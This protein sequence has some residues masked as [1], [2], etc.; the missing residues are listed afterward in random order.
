MS[1]IDRRIGLL[2]A[3]FVLLLVAVAARAA[4]VQGVHGG[5][6]SADAAGQ[7]SELLDVPAVRGRIMDRNHRELAVSEDAATIYATPYQV[8]DPANAARRLGAVL[9]RDPDDILK[10]LSVRDSGFEYVAQKVNLGVAEAVRKLD[11]EGIGVLPDSR[12][13][14]P[15]G[16][17]AGA[18]IGSVGADN[19]GLT[20]L[21]ASE[22]SVLGGT[23]GERQITYDAL[24]KEIRRDTVTQ[25]EA[26]ANLRLTIDAGLQEEAERVVDEL[27]VNY[28]PKGASAIVMNPRTGDVLAM[29]NYP[30][31]DPTDPG[32]ATP[33]ELRN[34]ATGYTFEP[35]S[36][37]KAFTVSGAIDDGVV[38]PDTTFYLPSQ[39]RVADRVIEEAHARPPITATVAQILAQS[40]N[41]GTVKIGQSLGEERFDDWVHRFGFGKP[42][43]VQF[44]G[45]ESGI[46]PTADEY[47]GS[48]I[49]NLPIGQG[50]SVTP[51][52]MAAGYSAIANGGILRSPRL[53]LEEDGH[54]VPEANG[55]RVISKQTASE[56][57]TMLE[58]VTQ[59][60]GTASEVNVPGYVIAGKTGTAQK[61]AADGTYSD[62]HF[63]ASFV[64][65]APADDPGVLISVVVD[66]PQ[67]GDY[68]GASVAGPAFEQIA[69][70][71]LP[72]LGVPR[73]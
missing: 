51:L 25:P 38:T 45:E 34:M 29:A 69:D 60:G 17:L 10:A 56:V 42:T 7:Q 20:G 31:A 57:R 12:R 68:Y 64:G 65:F 36:T 9:D 63:V 37:F 43:G 73:G 16:A 13:V 35:G 4:W 22:Q 15:E 23:D 2:F 59:E 28:S 61:I 32:S 44:P 58:G 46:V 8:K 5:K 33:E 3:V 47:S 53:V 55:H 41:V 39:L 67:G 40:S 26:G 72:Y 70:F 11:I 18:V 27:G 6:L 48:S 54:R 66:D 49:G 52:Q 50:I 14:Y 19:R 21:E 1:L 30:S 24:G 71:A 62:T